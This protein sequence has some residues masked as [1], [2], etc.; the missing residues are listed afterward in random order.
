MFDYINVILLNFFP[1][2]YSISPL[3]VRAALKKIYEERAGHLIVKL[4][5]SSAN[6]INLC[7]RELDSADCKALCFALHYS[8]GVKLNLLNSVIPN[9]EIDSIVKLM[10]RVSE[11]R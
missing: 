10:H 8:D 7:T 11:L 6:L 3:F 1:R 2:L 4:V 5:Q 9:N